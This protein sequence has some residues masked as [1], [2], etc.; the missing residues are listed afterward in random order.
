MR[1]RFLTGLVIEMF[2]YP[3]GVRGVLRQPLIY[4]TGGGTRITVGGGFV[5]NLASIPGWAHAIANPWEAHAWAAVIHDALYGWQPCTRA[6]ADKI[7]L[8]A[9]LVSGTPRWK[10][11][12]MYWAVRY[13]GEPYWVSGGE[14]PDGVT[15]RW[16]PRL[17]VPTRDDWSIS[18]QRGTS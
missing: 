7:F 16:L 13:A 15:F 17:L 9:M 11:R 6:E 4:E 8:E 3:E 2:A 18:I 5:T 10:A 14:T 12:L 1:G